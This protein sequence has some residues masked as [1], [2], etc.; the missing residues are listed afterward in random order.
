MAQRQAPVRFFSSGRVPR[1]GGTGVFLPL[2]RHQN[3]PWKSRGKG[4][5][6]AAHRQESN[7]KP[8]GVAKQG[9]PFQGRREMGLPQDWTY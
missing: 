9:M 8:A 4:D 7:H 3:E 5:G 2:P 6:A 1:Y